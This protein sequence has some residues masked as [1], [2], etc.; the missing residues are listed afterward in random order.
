M[1]KFKNCKFRTNLL[2]LKLNFLS[3]SIKA[4]LNVNAKR[5]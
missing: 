2:K 3:S 5:T 1:V 4:N